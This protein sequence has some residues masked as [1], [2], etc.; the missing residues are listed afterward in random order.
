[1]FIK[2][3]DNRPGFADKPR[4]AIFDACLEAA[5]ILFIPAV[6]DSP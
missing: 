2:E 1:M 3:A 5:R 4:H 6:D